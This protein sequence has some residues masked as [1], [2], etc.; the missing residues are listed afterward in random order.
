MTKTA[1]VI[2][3]A[4][5][6]VRMCADIPKVLMGM[7]GKPMVVFPVEVAI[8]TCNGPI[9][10]VCGE[11]T[12]DIRS[13]VADWVP[14]D[15]VR[16]AVQPQ[17][18]GTADAVAHGI[19][20]LAEDEADDVLILNGDIPALPESLVVRLLDDHARGS[21]GLSLITARVGDP[22]GYGRMIRNASGE[23]TA[24]REHKELTPDQRC[25][26]E[27][28]VG[29]YVTRLAT[30]R[31]HL[32]GLEPSPNQKEFLLTDLVEMVSGSGRVNALLA[33]D[34]AEVSGI[35]N[36][37][38]FSDVLRVLRSRRNRELMVRGVGMP[39][40]ESVDVD[41]RV[42]VAPNTMLGH[43]VSLRGRTRIGTRCLIDSGTVVEDCTIS[44]NVQVL[45]YCVLESSE[46]HSGV[47]I[48]PFA[49]TRAGTVLCEKSKV[50]NFVETK[51]TI[52]GEGS[53]ANHLTYLGDSIIGKK[54]NVGAGTITCNYDGYKKY[55]TILEDGV[56]V[57][58]DT[59]LVAPV[60]VGRNAVIAAG[61]TVTKDVPE[62]SL[63]L[64]RAPQTHKD[65]YASAKRRRMQEQGGD[66]GHH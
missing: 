61:T 4:G 26:D 28:N 51:K 38:E 48:G 17:P 55:Q 25:I 23:V 24:I 5:K 10:I 22:S 16:F 7:L 8:N 31:K 60:K 40:P 41:Y 39:H 3:A 19:S 46:I 33:P 63:A 6:G 57:G 32:P 1:A 37:A 9:V 58:S 52:L 34:V 14:M 50:G 65:G 2:M 20:A 54:V 59:Q 62:D 45:P 21:A 30:L 56:F 18:R 49:H 13:A 44:D 15:R 66:G 36:R 35:N 11:F 64:S 47:Q 42:E 53:K 12:E 29:V 27:I 43:G